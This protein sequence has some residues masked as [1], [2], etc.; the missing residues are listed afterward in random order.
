MNSAQDFFVQQQVRAVQSKC[1]LA[2][3]T[4]ASTRSIAE[5]A[6]NA[7]IIVPPY[8][9]SV[10]RRETLLVQQ[11]AERRVEELLKTHYAELQAL[12]GEQLAK[13]LGQLQANE[14]RALSGNFPRLAQAAT[15]EAARFHQRARA[16]ASPPAASGIPESP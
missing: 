2:M 16:E 6:R 3:R 4:I 15:R 13:R 10:L 5:V 12:P 7:Q 8:L 14:W 1:E 9:R 11:A